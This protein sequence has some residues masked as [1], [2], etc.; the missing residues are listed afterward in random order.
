MYLIQITDFSPSHL[1]GSSTSVGCPGNCQS[2]V[3]AV[4]NVDDVSPFFLIYLL[5]VSMY[6][7]FSLPLGITPSTSMSNTVLVIWLSSLRLTCPYQRSRFCI[8]CVAIGW[9]VAASLISSFLL[10]SIRLTPCIH[11]NILISDV[12]I[13]ISS[14][15]ISVQHSA[16]YVIVGFITVLYIL[17]LS[18][19]GT[20]LSQVTPVISL[21]LFQTSRTLF[22]Q[23]T[24][25]LLI[26]MQLP[27]KRNI[28]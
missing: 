12:F 17:C 1:E 4:E 28:I 24:D 27:I 19:T 2:P 3:L 15:F 20:F 8:R 5:M 9:T 6:L 26:N 7:N 14:F 22:L 16:P 21:H 25:G 18:L 11:R 23:I 10:C 13:S